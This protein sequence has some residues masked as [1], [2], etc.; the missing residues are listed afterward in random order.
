MAIQPAAVKRVNRGLVRVNR[1]D[2]GG[3]QRRT[4]SFRCLTGGWWPDMVGLSGEQF[5]EQTLEL[6]EGSRFSWQCR[7]AARSCGRGSKFQHAQTRLPAQLPQV[8]IH[9]LTVT[10]FPLQLRFIAARPANEIPRLLQFPGAELRQLGVTAIDSDTRAGEPA[11]RETG[12]IRGAWPH[13]VSVYRFQPVRFGLKR[14]RRPDAG[15]QA[16]G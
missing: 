6:M 11:T 10:G 14:E 5:K 8:L 16:C 2:R 7:S 12:R 1:P 9:Q 4:G 13:R 3:G 15:H